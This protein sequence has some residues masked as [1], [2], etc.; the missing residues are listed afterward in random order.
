MLYAMVNKER[1]QAQMSSI[2]VHPGNA[3]EMI[4]LR[5]AIED[6]PVDL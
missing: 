5:I 1:L 4:A 2:W 3:V 6:I